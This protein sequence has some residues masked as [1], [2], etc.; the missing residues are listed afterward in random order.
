MSITEYQ[1]QVF[2]DL[3][4]L[5]KNNEVFYYV[6][7]RVNDDRFRVF[8][9]RLAKYSDWLHPHALECRGIV[10]RLNMKGEPQALVCWPFP[11]FFNLHENP[12]TM[13]LDLNNPKAIM[14]KMDGSIMSSMI[15]GNIVWLKSNASLTSDHAYAANNVLK[16][17]DVLYKFTKDLTLAGYTVIFEFTSP[18][19]DFRI[20]VGYEESALT[21]LAVRNNTTGQIYNSSEIFTEVTFNFEDEYEGI[22]NYLVK[23]IVHEV[24][25]PH[26]FVEKIPHMTDIEGYV[27]RLASGQLV[28]IKTEWYMKLHHI[29]D[30]INSKRRLYEAVVYDTIDDIRSRF[31]DNEGAMK[32][33]D[34]MQEK[35]SEIY[36]HMVVSVETYHKEN[37]HLS[38]KDYAIKGK[39]TL[40]PIHFGLAMQMYH[41]RKVDFKA[42]MIKHRKNFGIFD[43]PMEIK[44][45]PSEANIEE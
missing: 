10:F 8:H 17:H 19:P 38:Q 28:K 32:I 21:I 13:D 2:N 1:T 23:D 14:E 37:K 12:F 20:V 27:V 30:S 44:R 33:I 26:A 39:S 25:D 42:A 5:C 40:D 24:D 6:D 22:E 31:F 11:K 4:A 29:Q 36:N 34:E 3:M 16:R 7:Q 43:D 15:I 18:H 45:I 35:V 41:G 9:Y